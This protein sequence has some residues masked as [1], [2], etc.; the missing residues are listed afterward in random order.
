MVFVFVVFAKIFLFLDEH[1][2]TS[3]PGNTPDYSEGFVDDGDDSD[4]YSEDNSAIARIVIIATAVLGV[5]LIIVLCAI[6]CK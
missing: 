4:D 1:S 2:V 3:R 5:L 6:L